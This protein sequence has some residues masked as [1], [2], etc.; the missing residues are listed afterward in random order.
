MSLN[1]EELKKKYDEMQ[2][3]SG[4]NNTDFS[5]TF[6]NLQEGTTLVRI[7]PAKDPTKSFYVESKI[8]HIRGDE[9]GANVHCRRTIDEECPL[10]NIYENVWDRFKDNESMV[11][12]A[13]SIKPRSKY[14]VNVLERETGKVKI[15]SMGEKLFGIILG[16]CLDPDFGDV[17]DAKTGNDLKIVKNIIK[18]GGDSWPNYDSSNFRPKKEPLGSDAQVAEWMD[19]LHNLESLVKILDYDSVKEIAQNVAPEGLDP[20]YRSRKR[21]KG[22]FFT[23]KKTEPALADTASAEDYIGKLK[24]K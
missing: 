12:F 18:A 11:K 13:R 19:Q 5:D 4:G 20:A 22:S 24:T 1:Y 17:T 15:L 10:C 8:H 3:K 23:P 9:G 14:Y 16:A 2:K 7:L 21:S 6:L